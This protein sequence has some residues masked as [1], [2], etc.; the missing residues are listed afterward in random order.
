MLGKVE[1]C[2][3]D[4]T[5]SKG[6]ATQMAKVIGFRERNI[7]WLNR[8]LRRHIDWGAC[9]GFQ[10]SIV[11]AGDCLSC[12]KVLALGIWTICACAAFR[13]QN[14]EW[15]TLRSITHRRNLQ[16]LVSN[17]LDIQNYIIYSQ[18]HYCTVSRIW[19]VVDRALWTALK[20]FIFVLSNA[21]NR[22]SMLRQYM[23]L[24][25]LPQPTTYSLEIG[26]Y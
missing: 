1:K 11:R 2:R 23:V 14:K 21:H 13:G 7:P 4:P 20:T 5:V 3:F 18:S 15:C 25:F 16:H 10:T 24:G 6:A 9:S 17:D 22:M 8:W 12:C 19:D 26:T